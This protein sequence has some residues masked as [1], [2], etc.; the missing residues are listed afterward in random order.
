[1][2]VHSIDDALGRRQKDLAI[3]NTGGGEEERVRIR[4]PEN[5]SSPGSVLSAPSAVKIRILPPRVNI[6]SLPGDRPG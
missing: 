5:P 6:R 3:E 4:D 2:A 1:M